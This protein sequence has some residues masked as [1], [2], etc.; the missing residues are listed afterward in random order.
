MDKRRKTFDAVEWVRGIRDK[1]YEE[2]GHLPTKEFLRVL[3]ERGEMSEL[4]KKLRER[5]KKKQTKGH[6]R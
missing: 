3:A 4:G 5:T 6:R 2:L 1:N